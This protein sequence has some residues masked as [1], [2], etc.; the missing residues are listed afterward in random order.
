MFTVTLVSSVYL[1]KT[2]TRFITVPAV[3]F[4]STVA[5]K[6]MTMTEVFETFEKY[7]IMFLALQ[8]AGV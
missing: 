5:L 2:L 3:A 4:E 6:V 1:P 7:H 8:L